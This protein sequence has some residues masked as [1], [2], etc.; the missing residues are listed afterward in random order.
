LGACAISLAIFLVVELNQ[1]LEGFIN[2]SSAPLRNA[3]KHINDSS[4]R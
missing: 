1:P 4:G 3:L 2:V